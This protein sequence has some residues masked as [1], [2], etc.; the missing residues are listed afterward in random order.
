M[1]NKRHTVGKQEVLNTAAL[2]IFMH[3]GIRE[4]A[5]HLISILQ[6]RCVSNCTF[7]WNYISHFQLESAP[8]GAGA[9]ILNN[10][11]WK[12]SH[13]GNQMRLCNAHLHSANF[14]IL[15]L[16]ACRTLTSS[17]FSWFTMDYKTISPFQ[18][19][20]N[21]ISARHLS[22]SQKHIIHSKDFLSLSFLK[23]KGKDE[24]LESLRISGRPF[25]NEELLWA[26]GYAIIFSNQA[27]R[28]KPTHSIIGRNIEFP[29]DEVLV[30]R[31]GIC[32]PI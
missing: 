4:Y 21:V 26:S 6:L 15:R 12:A 28:L 8:R 22:P 2:K 10:V 23:V 13:A 18:T 32:N 24:S 5:F 11:E 19:T 25:Y 27:W 7:L 9:P 17:S 29:V 31:N 20:K 1:I 3:A 16:T 14:T 30:N